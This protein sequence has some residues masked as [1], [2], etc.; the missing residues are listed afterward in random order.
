MW[1]AALATAVLLLVV[2]AIQVW[3][4]GQSQ[5]PRRALVPRD[6]VSERACGKAILRDWIWD[7][8]VDGSYARS[9]Y[10][11]LRQMLPDGG[12]VYGDAG[13]LIDYVDEKL[14]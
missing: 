9:C 8:R 4:G 5:M 12:A 3:H 11:A 6:T 14:R 2:L 10:E 7:D 13:S 1:R